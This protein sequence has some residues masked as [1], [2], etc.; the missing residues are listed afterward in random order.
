MDANMGKRISLVGNVLV[1]LVLMGCSNSQSGSK[2]VELSG[3]EKEGQVLKS[4]ANINFNFPDHG[5]AFESRNDL[6]DECFD[7]MQSDIQIIDLDE[8]TDTIRIR[9]LKTR[10]D[11]NVLTGMY[12]TGMAY[13]H[14]KTLYVVADSSEKVKPPIKHELMHL[15]AMLE[16]G[17]PHNTSTWINE[18]LATYAEDNCNGYSVSEIY[19][20]FLDTDQLIHVDSLTTDFYHQPEMVG[21]HQSAYVVEYLLNNYSINQF[22]RLWKEG[23]DS[24]ESIYSVSFHE[25]QKELD[26]SILKEHPEV[27]N[28]DWETFKEGCM[29]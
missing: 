11:M 24:F 22:K 23:F 9:F 13:P 18:G 8:F 21:Y 17:Y 6:I 3:W 20:Y 7:A 16:W 4:I 15:I 28:I 2:S 25:M 19:R 1:L 26:K 14:N 10:N 27:P 5:F 29:K 12:A